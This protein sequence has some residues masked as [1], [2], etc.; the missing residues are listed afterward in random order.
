M[1]AT[2]ASLGIVPL[3]AL[4]GLAAVQAERTFKWKVHDM[5]RPAP[6][7]VDPGTAGSTAPADAI[8]LFAA[9]NPDLSKWTGNGSDAKWKV[10]GNEVVVE[11]GSGDIKT[12]EAFGDVQLHIEWMIPADRKVE[13]Q[14]GGNSGV[15]FYDRYEIQVLSSNG[16]VTYVDGMAG[17]LY[18]QYPP[19]VN[20]CRPQG[21]WNVYDIVFRGPVFKDGKLAQPAY[22]TVFLNGV[23]VQ[24]NAEILG[25]TAHGARAQYSPHE[26]TGPIRL[27]DHGD[28]IHFRNAWARKLAP[29]AAAE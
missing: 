12:K 17:S 15:F 16:N 7:V 2:R 1:N 26:A 23:L 11:P 27:Q 22:A 5:S 3:V 24:D 18:G 6:A 9:S 25:A 28:P 20:A 14:H 8:I 10:N 13:G 29:R 4:L 21:Q 19:L